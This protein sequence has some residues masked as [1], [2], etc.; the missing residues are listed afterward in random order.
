MKCFDTK[1][2]KD[3]KNPLE[4]IFPNPDITALNNEP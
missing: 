4:T 1:I 3:L 2:L